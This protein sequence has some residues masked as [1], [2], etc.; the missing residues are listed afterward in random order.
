MIL[1]IMREKKKPKQS[2]CVYTYDGF[3]SH[4]FYILDSRSFDG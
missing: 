1:I 2:V 4:S 3:E